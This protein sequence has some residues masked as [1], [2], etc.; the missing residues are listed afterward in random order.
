MLSTHSTHSLLLKGTVLKRSKR[1]PAMYVV[2][3]FFQ[4][5]TL[6]MPNCT[7]TRIWNATHPLRQH[8]TPPICHYLRYATIVVYS[9]HSGGTDE[10]FFA[11]SLL[12][13]RY[14]LLNLRKLGPERSEPYLLT[15]HSVDIDNCFKNLVSPSLPPEI[16]RN[17]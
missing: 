4:K 2:Q 6:F 12:Y 8:T 16:V 1:V 15:C 13:R 7:Y 3:T 10:A 14:S 9:L 17:P 11:V 5:K